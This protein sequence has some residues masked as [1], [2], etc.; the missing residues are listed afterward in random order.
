M[1]G[2]CSGS[3]RRDISHRI[4]K[5]LRKISRARQNTKIDQI[6]NDFKGLKHIAG[7]RSGGKKH[8]LTS[9]M[10]KSGNVVDDRQ[11][12]VDVF[13]EFYRELYQSAPLP[14]LIASS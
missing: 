3:E 11:S 13:A 8:R 7:I 2:F 10:D 4:R 12:I 6:L 1:C 5:E 14:F 9:V